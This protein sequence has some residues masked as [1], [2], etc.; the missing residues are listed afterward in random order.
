MPHIFVPSGNSVCVAT[1]HCS[2][3][4]GVRRSCIVLKP[5]NNSPYVS[6]RN[7]MCHS[8]MLACH[9]SEF[10]IKVERWSSEVLYNEVCKHVVCLYVSTFFLWFYMFSTMFIF[11]CCVIFVIVV[12]QHR[13]CICQFKLEHPPI[14]F[15]HH[16]FRFFP[17]V[18]LV[19]KALH[20][21]R[22]WTLSSLLS[23]FHFLCIYFSFVFFFSLVFFS[24]APVLYLFFP[25]WW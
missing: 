11:C 17:R 1:L 23:I 13:E 6:W 8:D 19:S 18:A 4:F 22:A 20:C 7:A 5:D 9:F 15:S 25:C 10:H 12:F 2:K 14:S 16:G 21:L 3:P 24:Y